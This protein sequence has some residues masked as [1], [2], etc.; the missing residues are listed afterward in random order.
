VQWEVSVTCWLPVGYLL[1]TC[2]LPVGYLLVT[3]RLP[4]GYLSVTCWLPVGY[5]SQ[6]FMFLNSIFHF[7]LTFPF[8]SSS[9]TFQTFPVLVSRSLEEPLSLFWLRTASVWHSNWEGG[10]FSLF[11]FLIYFL[12]RHFIRRDD[13][14]WSLR[15]IFLLLAPQLMH[16]HNI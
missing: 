6:Y 4:V 15:R 9:F 10:N 11:K 7:P 14:T 5:L 13:P 12:S 3:C 2:R 16:I 1:V 8:Y